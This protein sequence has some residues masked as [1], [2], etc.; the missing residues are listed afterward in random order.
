M[1]IYFFYGYKKSK[2]R[3]S[4]LADSGVNEHAHPR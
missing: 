3:A 2:L 4:M 1:V